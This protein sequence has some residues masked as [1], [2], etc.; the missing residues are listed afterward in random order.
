MKNILE[1]EFKI[2]QLYFGEYCTST[3]MYFCLWLFKVFYVILKPGGY[4]PAVYEVDKSGFTLQ[5]DP[6]MQYNVS[7]NWNKTLSES[8]SKNYMHPNVRFVHCVES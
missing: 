7:P 3:C 1:V 8:Q 2:L 5:Y 4:D 6:S